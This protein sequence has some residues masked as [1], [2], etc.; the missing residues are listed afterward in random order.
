[1]NPQII[2][3]ILVVILIL[4]W[5]YQCGVVV[6]E[7][8]FKIVE[9]FTGRFIRIISGSK[10]DH[11]ATQKDVDNKVKDEDGTLVEIGDIIPGNDAGPYDF[12]LWPLQRIS[13]YR[14]EKIEDR[15]SADLTDEEK[16]I[17]VWGDPSKDKE[18][19][20]SKMSIS[21]HYRKQY[22]YKMV[23]EG[24]ATGK[25]KGA[26]GSEAQNVKMTVKIAVTTCT[27]NPFRTRYQEGD[28]GKWLSTMHA[29]IMSAL[30]EIFGARSFDDISELRTEKLN[31]IKLK[32]GRTFIQRID[33]EMLKVKNLGQ[34][35]LDMNFIADDVMDESKDFVKAKAEAVRAAIEKGAAADR[36]AT[37][38]LLLKPRVD[39]AKALMQENTANQKDLKKIPDAT[40][41]SKFKSLAE[42]NI[43]VYVDGGTDKSSNGSSTVDVDKIVN[44]TISMDIVKE[45]NDESKSNNFNKNKKTV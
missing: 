39:A 16:K 14:M 28:G 31:D 30:S 15:V 40:T 8:E 24:L 32:D 27:R 23:F 2:A 9:G 20:I 12:I 4:I 45:I 6:K 3:G 42:S 44:G 38:A 37:E 34:G 10:G 7:N 17:I 22:T 33:D 29:V 19:S 18:V 25:T 26:H 11:A 1:M 43:R 13:T 5:L 41:V 36:S 21:N 35:V